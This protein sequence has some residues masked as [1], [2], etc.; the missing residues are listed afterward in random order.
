MVVASHR[1]TDSI[2][3]GVRVPRDGPCAIACFPKYGGGEKFRVSIETVDFRPSP[4]SAAWPWAQT[5]RGCRANALANCAAGEGP[6]HFHQLFVMNPPT[7]IRRATRHLLP[8]GEGLCCLSTVS[9]HRGTPAPPIKR[10]GRLRFR[11]R[12]AP[13]LRSLPWLPP[14]LVARPAC[15]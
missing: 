10:S 7:L 9:I 11:G 4:A 1:S 15:N 12:L 5:G 3:A 14:C 2:A 8:G 13:G 6:S